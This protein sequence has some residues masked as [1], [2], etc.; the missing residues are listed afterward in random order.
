ML[1]M[2]IKKPN[3][4]FIYHYNYHTGN[5]NCVAHTTFL[6]IYYF[7]IGLE[8]GLTAHLQWAA[9]GSLP[10]WRRPILANI[11]NPLNYLNHLN[12]KYVDLF[13]WTSYLDLLFGLCFLGNF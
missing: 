6:L 10:N 12:C 7:N 4:Y 2:L 5:K 3:N 9:M 11:P 13:I 1:H 8:Y